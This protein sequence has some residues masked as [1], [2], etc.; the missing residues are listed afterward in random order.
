MIKDFALHERQHYETKLMSYS[1]VRI[2]NV[3]VRTVR[4]Y[5]QTV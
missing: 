5:L 2:A 4:Q 3:Y 1:N